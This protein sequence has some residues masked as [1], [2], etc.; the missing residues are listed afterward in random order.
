MVLAQPMVSP[1]HLYFPL[2]V[3]IPQ[4]PPST[5]AWLM[6]HSIDSFSL[7]EIMRSPPSFLPWF[8]SSVIP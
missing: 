2:C 4:S 3:N 5:M 6:A 1:G 7:K 8:S